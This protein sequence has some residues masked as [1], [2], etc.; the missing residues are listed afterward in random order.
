MRSPVAASWIHRNRYPIIEPFREGDS[1][2]VLA[3]QLVA[4]LDGKERRF[5]GVSWLNPV[6]GRRR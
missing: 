3:P 4:A 1:A 2:P 5:A 6:A